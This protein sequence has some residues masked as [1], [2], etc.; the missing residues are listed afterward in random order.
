MLFHRLRRQPGRNEEDG[1]RDCIR[2]RRV[3]FLRFG[4][5]RPRRSSPPPLLQRPEVGDGKLLAHDE[6]LHLQNCGD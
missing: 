3:S 5:Y 6:C 4:F 2:E 1:E